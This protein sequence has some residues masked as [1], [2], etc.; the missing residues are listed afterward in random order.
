MFYVCIG[1]GHAKIVTKVNFLC[2][3]HPLD[4]GANLEEDVVDAEGVLKE[5]QLNEKLSSKPKGAVGKG[6][7]YSFGMKRDSGPLLKDPCSSKT[8]SLAEI[9]PVVNPALSGPLTIKNAKRKSSQKTEEDAIRKTQQRRNENK[10][11]E[12]EATDSTIET[13]RGRITRS[14]AKPTN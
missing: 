12:L 2:L 4:L 14:S 1:H 11:A 7:R 3:F 10:K 6:Q 13:G 5:D 9:C 8:I